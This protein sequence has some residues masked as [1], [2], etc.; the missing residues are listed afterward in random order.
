M[1]ITVLMPCLNE[2]KT[3]VTCIRKAKSFLESNHYEGEILISDNGS[4]DKSA[5]IAEEAGAR[6]VHIDDKGYGSALI[7]GILEAQGGYIIMG[8]ADDSYDFSNLN[9]FIEKLDEGYDLVMG[10]R[11]KGEIKSGA[12]PF[13]HRYIGNP[14]LSGIGRIFYKT[15]VGDFHCGLR[16]FRKDSILKLNLCTTGM[17]FASEMVVKAVLFKLK[18]TE[19]P[20][21]LYPDGRDRA[22]HLRSFHDGWRHLKFLL[23]Y[24][25]NWLFLYPGLF[26]FFLGALCM[27]WLF[28][29]PISIAGISFEIT[30][31]F[32][33][34][35]LTILGLSTAMFSLYTKI[36]AARIGQIPHSSKIN[37]FFEKITYDYG[38]VIGLICL[39]FG[40]GGVIITLL[41][42]GQTGF[43]GLETHLVYKI[44]MLSGTLVIW[45]FQLIFGS[46][47]VGV[48]QMRSGKEH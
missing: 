46:F 4:T 22:P 35:M 14:I 8:D 19:V 47:F 18:I 9:P 23:L 5:I 3:V 20:I 24:S 13:L 44:A 21:V 31:M 6:V 32:Y 29:A 15:D 39:L 27:I 42:W 30:T 28:I 17:E 12:M 16:A 26:F 45:G 11:F 48:L 36:Y 40:A 34:A 10:N 43:G 7:G 37:T 38:I 1:K 2:E 25:P 41:L 33:C